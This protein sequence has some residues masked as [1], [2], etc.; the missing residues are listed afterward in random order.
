MNWAKP[1]AD[2]IWASVKS[3][4]ERELASGSVDPAGLA[5]WIIA[6]ELDKARKAG[7]EEAA[8]QF[9]LMKD[10]TITA[11]LAAFVVRAYRDPA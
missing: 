5:A 4:M 10:N 1:I 9:D 7:I 6:H 2:K 8:E 11:D 3:E